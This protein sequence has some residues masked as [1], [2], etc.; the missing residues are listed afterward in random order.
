MGGE[1]VLIKPV[2][3]VLEVFKTSGLDQLFRIVSTEDEIAVI[4]FVQKARPE[5]IS[6]EVE[7]IAME[8]V[9]LPADKGSLFVIGSQG[10]L[11]R[12]EYTEKDVATVKPEDMQFGTGLAALG[13]KFEDYKH[14]FGE[15]MVINRNFFVYPAI[16]HSDC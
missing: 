3:S 12:S 2:S 7:G 11:A 13:E 14:L 10:P 8:Y 15:S 6:K 5:V 4:L 1:I 16:K 9:G